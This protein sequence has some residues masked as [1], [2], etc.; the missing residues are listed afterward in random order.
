MMR[1]NSQFMW[2]EKWELSPAHPRPD[3]CDLLA[4]QD[5][6]GEGAGIYKTAP[7]RHPMCY[8]YIYPVYRPKRGKGTYPNVSPA[9]PQTD[10]LDKSQHKLAAELT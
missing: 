7:N 8:C 2:Y 4:S 10:N 5:P 6:E 9:T 3:V 1:E